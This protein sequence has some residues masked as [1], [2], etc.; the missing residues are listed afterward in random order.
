MAPDHLREAFWSKIARPIRGIMYHGWG[1]LAKAQHGS[2]RFT[3]PRSAEVL[4]ELVRTVVR[5]LGPTLLQ[6]PDRQA[7]VAVLES[8]T[9]QMFAGRGTWGWSGS[10]EADVH[11]ILQWAQI[12]PRIVY[13]ETILRDGLDGIRVLVL[14]YCDVLPE[15]VAEAIAAFQRKGGIL[16]ADAHLA[17]RLN[18]DILLPVY[19]RTNKAKKDKAALQ[20]RAAALRAELDA[21]YVRH[22]ESDNPDVVLRFRQYRTTDYL[23]AINDH[24]TFG[25]YVGHHGRVME[26]GLPSEAAIT[27]RRKAGAVYD[28]VAHQPVPF[29]QADEGIRFDASFGPGQGRLFLIAARPI[30]DLRLRAPDEAPLGGQAQLRVE[31]LDDRKRPMAAVVPVQVEILDP[32]GRP[33]E[34][35][36][37]YGARDGVLA[38][39]LDLAPNDLQGEWTVRATELASGR[40]RERALRVTGQGGDARR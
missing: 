17:P 39:T 1:S 37:A 7:D 24:R 22:G 20:A 31:V 25:T 8:F 15:S 33:A 35:S 19:E 10:W 30:A 6:V 9:S 36:G 16:V 34:G 40:S 4:T 23:F 2:Y 14:P 13:E 32:Q 18:P 26:K 38:I 29:E 5:P 12:Q 21:A 27:V 11:L 3:H 28:L